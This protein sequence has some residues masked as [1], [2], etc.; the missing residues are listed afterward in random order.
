M[1]QVQDEKE[2][3]LWEIM[4][5]GYETILRA[6]KIFYVFRGI[7]AGEI[8]IP[9]GMED[10][11]Q[12]L[13]G[14]IFRIEEEVLECGEF[15]LDKQDW[16][17]IKDGWHFLEACQIDLDSY[18]SE[19]IEDEFWRRSKE[20]RMAR[21]KSQ[22]RT[23]L[24][25]LD[26]FFGGSNFSTEKEE[27]EKDF[28]GDREDNNSE[29]VKVGFSV[30]DFFSSQGDE[31]L[32]DTEEE[33]DF[34]GQGLGDNSCQIQGV[35]VSQVVNEA[36][37]QV[38]SGK[39]IQ[40][41]DVEALT[42]LVTQVVAQVLNEK[43]Q[44]IVCE[45]SKE[46]DAKKGFDED[47]NSVTKEEDMPLWE[48]YPELT[49]HPQFQR[50]QELRGQGVPVKD[51]F[52]IDGC[53]VMDGKVYLSW[54]LLN[55]FGSILLQ[56]KWDQSVQGEDR[57]AVETFYQF[58]IDLAMDKKANGEA[59]KD[60]EI[61]V[62]TYEVV[63]DLIRRMRVNVERWDEDFYFAE[64]DVRATKVNAWD[65]VGGLEEI[66][67]KLNF[68]IKVLV[69]YLPRKEFYKKGMEIC[70]G[71]VFNGDSALLKVC[72][73]L[74]SYAKYRY[75]LDL[76]YEIE[77]LE[78]LVQKLR[79]RMDRGDSEESGIKRYQNLKKESKKKKEE[80]KSSQEKVSIFELSK[81][82]SKKE[83][84]E[85][86][87]PTKEDYIKAYK[88]K[89]RNRWRRIRRMFELARYQDQAK[90]ISEFF[91]RLRTDRFYKVYYVA[92]K[93]PDRY[94][95]TKKDTKFIQYCINY[96]TNSL[97]SRNWDKVQ[98][99]EKKGKEG[100]RKWFYFG[101]WEVDPEEYLMSNCNGGLWFRML[102]AIP[103]YWVLDD[104]KEIV[105]KVGK[106]FDKKVGEGDKPI[107]KV[108]YPVLQLGKVGRGFKVKDAMT[109]RGKNIY[110]IV[111]TLFSILSNKQDRKGLLYSD[112]GVMR[113]KALV[114]A[115][116]FFKRYV[117]SLKIGEVWGEARFAYLRIT[118]G[119]RLLKFLTTF[120][121]NCI[122]RDIKIYLKRAGPQEKYRYK[123]LYVFDVLSGKW[124]SWE[125]EDYWDAIK[126]VLMVLDWFMNERYWKRWNGKL[127]SY[128]DI[129]SLGGMTGDN[130]HK[131]RYEREFRNR[132]LSGFE[133]V[134]KLIRFALGFR[135]FTKGDFVK[136]KQ[137]AKVYEKDKIDEIYL[138]KFCSIDGD[139]NFFIPGVTLQR[140]EYHGDMFIGNH[141]SNFFAWKKWFEG[142]E[143][144][145]Y[146]K[147]WQKVMH[148]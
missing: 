88:V 117:E 122:H 50:V 24:F 12:E 101:A 2:M 8:E 52:L 72:S 43:K 25:S 82:L 66:R 81:K 102:V 55:K 112:K 34:Q 89:W 20:L 45:E 97:R 42:N 48:R 35:D 100:V 53:S 68:Y 145:S 135:A 19:D 36:L 23:G 27:S 18:E 143:D 6:I 129:K 144:F 39:D 59:G 71:F 113:N 54:D 92:I 109:E 69:T 146:H 120:A 128:Y 40:G 33:K 105:E 85:L 58:F 13:K 94:V 37:C 83:W 26:D 115:S 51:C 79:E 139:G 5:S 65:D 140:T 125:V 15:M 98:N 114:K 118:R 31:F 64:R 1:E 138:K 60:V 74:L 47:Q 142:I 11:F 29:K 96:I 78:W 123:L 77:E 126:K 134:L 56:L 84:K 124:L 76:K 93:V 14:D 30:E 32:K 46:D 4:E 119:K 17:R 75:A 116:E 104:F 44:V 38:L 127:V 133:R 148:L 10:M 67:A 57:E 21:R 86:F 132:F 136:L 91:I 61:D 130:Y 103:P 121:K 99:R 137:D 106:V 87:S 49:L 7:D 110:N 16:E 28:F 22:G 73:D 141:I 111:F 131:M 147:N 9:Q 41:M 62:E 95:R 70:S 107:V 108:G 63:Y 80:V 3:E 90:F